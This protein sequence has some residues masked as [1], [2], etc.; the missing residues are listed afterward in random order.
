M[1]A[2]DSVYVANP[3]GEAPIVRAEGDVDMRAVIAWA[4]Q[5][6]PDL[7]VLERETPVCPPGFEAKKCDFCS[8]HG[9]V[10]HIKK[11]GV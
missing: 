2:L 11:E 9:V 4:L 5:F 10:C 6:R 7:V 1:K 8:G 3:G